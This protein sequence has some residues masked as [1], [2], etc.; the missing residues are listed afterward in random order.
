MRHKIFFLIGLFCLLPLQAQE[1]EVSNQI[2][3]IYDTA[4]QD[5]RAYPWLEHLSQQIGS[6][7]SR[8]LGAERAVS[9]GEEE[10]KSLGLD[11]VFLQPVMVPKWVR[12]NFEYANIETSPGNTINVPVCALGGS[13]ATPSAGIRAQVVEVQNFEE[14]AALG[15]EN[16]KGKFV[17]YNRPME[18]QL[19]NT[20]QAY[21]RAVDQRS[22]GAE[23][24]ARYGAVG[25]IVRSMNLKL[26]DYPH[27]GAMRYGDLP[28]KDRIPAAAISTNG[29]ELLSSMLKLNPS[30]R[31]F[32]KQNCK[33]YPDVLSYN[34]VGEIKGSV[35][36]ENIMVVG[37]HL[38][39]WDLGDGAHDDGAGIVQSME[40][41][42]IFKTLNYRPKNTL[43]VVL[44]M[45]E[46]NGTRGGKKYAALAQENKENHLFALESDAGGFTPRGF[47]FDSNAPAFEK[48]SSWKTY[49]A[50]YQ[51]HE[52]TQ[53]GSGA[54]IAPL[55]D[56]H[57]VLAGLRP[58]SQ[59]YFDHHHAA[60]DTFDGINKRELEL[61]A[62]AMA[63]LVYLVDHFGLE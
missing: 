21:S 11:R 42:R 33:N 40:V 15:T 24:A 51:I 30:L 4:L 3:A 25:V 50:P 45:N 13:I 19:I 31:F 36:P 6:R 54:D 23:E 39:S 44:F 20:F 28:L 38:D 9:W 37:G 43:R 14:L 55:K 27:T 53:G 10:L 41:A 59:R 29:A 12:G 16:I 34:V 49:F 62:A 18:A 48:I 61:G 56:G 35:T 58:D 2:R 52:F 63:T 22:R 8:S 47:S 32:L 46:E 1:P 60:T 57:V 17:F 5:G 26:D 7:L